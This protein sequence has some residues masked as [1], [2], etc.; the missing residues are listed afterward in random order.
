M[1]QFAGKF[2]R[3]V[4]NLINQ[5]DVSKT[6]KHK[7]GSFCISSSYS[8][9]QKHKQNTKSIASTLNPSETKSQ[10]IATINKTDRYP[11]RKN[12]KTTSKRARKTLTAPSSAHTQKK[13]KLKA[14]NKTHIAEIPKTN[15][16]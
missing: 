11:L 10:S 2:K 4:G 16:E 14:E 8:H 9:S 13:L 7:K 12:L 15:T 3:K 6:H 5:T 1:V